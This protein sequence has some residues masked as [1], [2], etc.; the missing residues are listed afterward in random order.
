M[1]APWRRNTLVQQIFYSFAQKYTQN[2][3]PHKDFLLKRFPKT[4]FKTAKQTQTYQPPNL[5]DFQRMLETDSIDG[6]T[7]LPLHWTCPTWIHIHIHRRSESKPLHLLGIEDSHIQHPGLT[8]A[9]QNR[10]GYSLLK[11]AHQWI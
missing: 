5:G 3:S 10:A 8:Q 1:Q 4:V 2:V 11:T 7:A 6:A 9:K